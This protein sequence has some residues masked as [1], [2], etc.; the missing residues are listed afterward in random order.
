MRSVNTVRGRFYLWG[1]QPHSAN[2]DV[3]RRELVLN[4]LLAGLAGMS[5]LALALSCISLLL[6]PQAQP[7]LS[8]FAV[9]FIFGGCVG[10][11]WYLSRRGLHRF[12]AGLT[13][14]I[15]WLLTVLLTLRW[16]VA[17]PEVQL[18]NALVIVTAGVLI[19]SRSSLAVVVALT[20]EVAVVGSL[21]AQNVLHPDTTWL[22]EPLGNPDIVGFLVV[23]IFLGVVAWLSNYETHQ[24]LKRAH[25]SE[26]ALARE[27]NSLE[28]KVGQRTRELEEAQM[29]RVQ[30]L[31]RFA[32]V[33]RMSSGILH[34]LA[35]P[36]TSARLNLE[37]LQATPDL[38]F[39]RGVT[40]SIG[41]L[42]RYLG[43]VRKQLQS[44][45]TV[46]RF[47][48][49]PEAEQ[50]LDILAYKARQAGVAITLTCSRCQLVGDPIKLHQLITN[51]VSN[52]IDAYPAAPDTEAEQ[53]VLVHI[54]RQDEDVVLTVQDHGRGIAPDRLG[55]VFEPFYTDKVASGDH[56][57]LGLATAKDVVEQDFGGTLVAS[58]DAVRGTQFVAH[59]RSQRAPGHD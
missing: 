59:L 8:S 3:R 7:N 38:E 17:L 11:L 20:L 13:V 19:G 30:E 27:R 18:L 24:S 46:R 28:Q 6:A 43:A 39:V 44:E 47:A 32:K 42:E 14:G 31:E 37:Q 45:S 15:I 57:G 58:S 50:A 16:S 34:D 12:S 22:A 36:L 35:Q 9:T 26:L 21:Q 53:V 10:S 29:Q 40:R 52:A 49:R 1:I 55:H 5:V 2:Q 4:I 54:E 33:G 56:V 48:V 23:L 51:L 25:R 41:Q